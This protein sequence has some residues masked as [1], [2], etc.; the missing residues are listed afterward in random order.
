MTTK[1]LTDLENTMDSARSRLSCCCNVHVLGSSEP[2]VPRPAGVCAYD[3]ENDE[4]G[5]PAFCN[6]STFILNIAA[7][8]M[9]VSDE[10]LRRLRGVENSVNGAVSDVHDDKGS[11]KPGKHDDKG[12]GKPGNVRASGSGKGKGKMTG[13][14]AEP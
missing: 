6:Q 14:I 4:D 12:S 1:T 10:L 2:V 8:L 13:M 9:M 3:E 5:N 11:G 7:D